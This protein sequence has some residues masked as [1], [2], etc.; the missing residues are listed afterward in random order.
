MSTLKPS[1]KVVTLTPITQLWNNNG[2]VPGQRGPQ[3]TQG[4][5]STLF[6]QGPVQFVIADIGHPFA[7]IPVENRFDFW[8][9]EL[10]T[11]LA[12]GEGF[13]LADYPGEYS[14][15]ALRWENASSIPT[16]VLEKHH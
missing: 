8:K 5:I 1:Q 13:D 9:D 2:R 12:E 11:H 6:K 16:V 3:L 4:D 14:Y 10:K 15:V 7:W